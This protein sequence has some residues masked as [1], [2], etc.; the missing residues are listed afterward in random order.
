[1]VEIRAIPTRTGRGF[2]SGT[3]RREGRLH[4]SD[5]KLRFWAIILRSEVRLGGLRGL[6]QLAV[7]NMKPSFWKTHGSLD[8]WIEV[9]VVDLVGRERNRLWVMGWE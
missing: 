1:M 2:F 5:G 4:Y 7:S 9:W 6:P 3:S 8:N